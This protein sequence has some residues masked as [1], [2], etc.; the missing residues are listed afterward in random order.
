MNKANIESLKWKVNALE[1][2]K[3][4]LVNEYSGMAYGMRNE[5]ELKIKQLKLYDENIIPALRN[6]YKTMQ[7]GYEQNTEELFMLFDAWE[8]LYMTQ[9]EYAELV[10]QALKLQVTIERLIEKK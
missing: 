7:L 8:T 10:N 5:L 1:S 2:Q 4:M 3:Q 6:N 9:L